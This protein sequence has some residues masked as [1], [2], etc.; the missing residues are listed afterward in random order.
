MRIKVIYGKSRNTV[1]TRCPWYTTVAKIE[2]GF[3]AFESPHD[4]INWRYNL[5]KSAL[6]P[7]PQRKER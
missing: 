5:T 4:Y 6:P 2:G 7:P 3:I 1:K